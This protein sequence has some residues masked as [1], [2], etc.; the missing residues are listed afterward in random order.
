[1]AR[2]SGISITDIAREAGVSITTVSRI[3]NRDGELKISDSTRER[4]LETAQ[5][6]GYEPNL[7]A[8]ALRSNRTGII[9]ALTPNLAGTFLPLLTM[10]LQRAARARG[11]ELLVGTPEMEPEQIEAQIRRLQSLLFD[12]LL[13]LGDVLDYQSTIRSL[14]VLHK[15]YVS[16]CAGLDLP[17]PLVNIDDEQATR[18]AVRY[19]YDLGHRRIAYL[20]STRWNQENSRARNFQQAMRA[21]GLALPPEY[22]AIMQHVIYT[23]FA[24]N[25]REMWTTQPLQTAQ[26]LLQLPT[27]PT[28]IFCA[29]DGFAIAAFKG[30][31]QLGLRVPADV[32]ILGYNDELHSTLFYPE[33][34]TIRQPLAQIAQAALDLLLRLL[35]TTDREAAHDTRVLVMPELVVRGTCAPPPPDAA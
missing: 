15:P 29:N 21:H 4:V 28:A 7:F 27:P 18:L 20:G 8:A 5:Q 1:M 11:V 32:S 33:L 13:L 14:Q 6:L 16:V 10:E 22:L 30:A 19:L 3:L 26:A 35:D 23:P 2:K 12:G 31:L 34:T 24:P 25:F 17:P 9:G